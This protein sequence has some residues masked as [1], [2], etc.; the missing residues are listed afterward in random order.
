M[1]A[2]SDSDRTLSRDESEMS[3]AALQPIWMPNPAVPLAARLLAYGFAALLLLTVVLALTRLRP[4]DLP[5]QP[6]QW[7]TY[8]NARFSLAF[9]AGWD[10][11]ETTHRPGDLQSAGVDA[12]QHTAFV[13]Y[14]DD[15]IRLDAF[16][17]QIIA[18]PASS[19]DAPAL[20]GTILGGEYR[21]Y[22][23]AP[24]EGDAPASPGWHAFTASLVSDAM[25]RPVSGAWVMQNEGTRVLLLAAV[26]TR[27]GWGI[28][29]KIL[30]GA[31]STVRLTPDAGN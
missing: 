19:L 27:N 2:E 1:T 6:A 11:T 31:A 30:A 7:Q 9:P 16:T 10:V 22:R 4:A 20:A 18:P 12:V 5:I 14:P 3:P 17:F 8:R 28:M 21:D 29:A 23:P 25:A 26:S 13:Q 24:P 15:Y